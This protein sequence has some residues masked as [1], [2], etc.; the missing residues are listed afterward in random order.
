MYYVYML[1]TGIVNIIII[2]LYTSYIWDCARANVVLSRITE[3]MTNRLIFHADGL[4]MMMTATMMMI[5]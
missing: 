1:S 4:Y 2:P 3:A 5:A